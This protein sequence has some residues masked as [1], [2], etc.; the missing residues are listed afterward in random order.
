M[1]R[2]KAAPDFGAGPRNHCS[3]VLQQGKI[4]AVQQS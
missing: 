2:S 1:L 4:F 3:F